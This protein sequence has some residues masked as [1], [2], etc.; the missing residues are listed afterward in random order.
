MVARRKPARRLLPA[1]LL[2]AVL[3][4]TALLSGCT[5]DVGGSGA[6]A[7]DRSV[8][9]LP[10]GSAAASQPGAGSKSGPTATAVCAALDKA[11]LKKLFGSDVQLA[12]S[13]SSGCV[14]T[15]TDGRA[16][17]VAVFDA[18]RLTNYQQGQ[19]TSLTVSS[20]PAIRTTSDILYV[21]LTSSRDAPG[22]IAA[23]FSGMGTDGNADAATITAQ[24]LEKFGK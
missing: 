23:Y 3:L 16:M 14:I 18:L 17:T 13:Q 15:A 22:L 11:K 21:A 20:H 1:F 2:A 12:Q 6:P 5:R 4:G 9:L 8:L 19:Y 24:L 7:E 10:S